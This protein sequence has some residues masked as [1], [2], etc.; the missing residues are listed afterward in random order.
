[1]KVLC[2]LQARMKSSRFPG[3]IMKPILGKPMI[4]H[5][6][7]SLSY[8]TMIDDV[9]V[10][11]TTNPKDDVLVQYLDKKNIKY[12]RG[13][14]NDVLKRYIDAVSQFGGD[15]VVRI[16]ADNPLTDP[17]IVDMVIRKA[18]KNKVDYASNNLQ[19]TFPLGFFVEVISRKI[20]EK[21]E[22]LT[23]DQS[24]REHV[25]LYIHKN[26]NSFKV[27]NLT[28][29]QEFFYPD[30]RLT[31]DTKEDFEL[32]KHVFEN[33]YTDHKPIRYEEVINFLKENPDLLKINQNIKQKSL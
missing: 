10:V 25:T 29:P 8:S 6:L 19:K 27:F 20:L 31:V 2:L 33:L 1:M 32:I 28:A 7:D 23:Q 18:L 24:D 22:K 5:I 9:I 21:L 12:F 30:W 14:E 11:T 15:Y 26:K 17:N 4:Q 16:T 13:N 3:K